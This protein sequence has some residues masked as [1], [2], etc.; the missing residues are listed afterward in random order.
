MTLARLYGW[1]YWQVMALPSDY[2]DE[3]FIALEID[4]EAEDARKTAEAERKRK[5]A[6]ISQMRAANLVILRKQGLRPVH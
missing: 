4:R 3:L 6:K 5:E 2:L 1:D